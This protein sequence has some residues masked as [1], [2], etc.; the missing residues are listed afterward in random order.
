[1]VVYE[2]A[3]V[4]ESKKELGVM[5]LE[6]ELKIREQDK[7][8]RDESARKLK[9]IAQTR[10]LV[11]LKAM[12]DYSR[13]EQIVEVRTRELRDAQERLHLCEK[14]A[15]NRSKLK[16]TVDAECLWV[17]TA[18]VAGFQQRYRTGRL[19]VCLYEVFFRT[20][21]HSI[22]NRAEIIATER[23]LLKVQERLSTEKAQLRTKVCLSP[24]STRE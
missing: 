3:V 21:V 18:T 1:M 23:Q 22:A 15:K 16:R 10:G 7:M 8:E 5:L 19:R 17:D 13:K 11:E 12:D 6:E 20:V 4:D 9:L 2:E 24:F 14:R